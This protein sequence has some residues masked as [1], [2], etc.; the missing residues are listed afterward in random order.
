MGVFP[1]PIDSA[2]R[3]ALVLRGTATAPGTCGELVQGTIEGDP[4][5][6]TCPIDLWSEVTVELGQW[7]EHSRELEKSYRALQM[8]LDY[9]GQPANLGSI[10]RNSLLPAS[11]GMASS[12]A[13]I[14]ATCLA[15]A[16]A[17]GQELAAEIIAK[18]ATSIEPSDGIMFPGI[19]I[20][21]HLTGEVKEYLG[22]APPLKLIIA[23]PGGT[24]DT[25]L[26]NHRKDLASK[27]L[28]KEPM[29][30]QAT[31]LVTKGLLTRDWE[32]L[33]RGASISAQANQVILPKP[34]LAQWLKWASDLQA[35][36][37]LV[38]HSGTVM[39]MLMHPDRVPAEEAAQYIRQKRPT[40]QV[41]QTAMVSGGL[42]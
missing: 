13:D 38:A 39:G 18:I 10:K 11:K 33:G 16:R 41:W 42:K 14:A 30:R 37:V 5:L 35:M 7:G 27:N 4:F 15:T 40:W 21:N 24:V 1:Y 31:D 9:L 34:Y 17:F 29:V 23:D 8:T 19:I 26:F 28:Q 12:S 3:N 20:C 25:I 6:I 22:P 32:M 2:D 36:G